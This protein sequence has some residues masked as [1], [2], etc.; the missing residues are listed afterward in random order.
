MTGK[1]DEISAAI[2]ELRAKA[3]SNA[4]SASRIFD[5][6]DEISGQLAG[7]A[8]VKESVDRIEPLVDKHERERNTGRGV[9]IG[10]SIA[11]GSAGATLATFGKA[12]LKKIGI[13]IL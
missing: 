6:L 7:V 12:A 11:S 3:D 13:D 9:L 5:K 1:L 4:R 10:L 8:A 2:G